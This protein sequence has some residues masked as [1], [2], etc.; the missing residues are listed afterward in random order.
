MKPF[1]LYS[2][3][4]GERLAFAKTD[5]GEYFDLFVPFVKAKR[6]RLI[7]LVQDFGDELALF[8]EFIDYKK[9]ADM[10]DSEYQTFVDD[11]SLCRES[12]TERM[13]MVP[14]HFKNTNPESPFKKHTL[15]NPTNMDE[16]IF[17]NKT[18]NSCDDCDD[19]CF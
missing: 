15:L 18:W 1:F 2:M 17:Q 4:K 14:K 9:I 19:P 3:Q 7:S 6:E 11:L 8:T 10:K 13:A 16:A 5:D 12:L